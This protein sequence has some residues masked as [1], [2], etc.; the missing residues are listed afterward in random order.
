MRALFKG[1]LRDHL[2]VD[3]AKL[4]STVF[5]DSMRVAPLTGLIA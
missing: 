5:P 4:D 2:G 1:V 3:R